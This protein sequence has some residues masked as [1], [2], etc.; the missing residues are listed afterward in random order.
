MCSVLLT[1]LMFGWWLDEPLLAGLAF[2]TSAIHYDSF[3]LGG[4]SDSFSA[5]K[6]GFL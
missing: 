3:V 5:W 4:R 1:G 2:A 6:A